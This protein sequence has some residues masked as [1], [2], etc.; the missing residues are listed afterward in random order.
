MICQPSW[1]DLIYY[2]G[3]SG[4][5]TAIIGIPLNKTPAVSMFYW[6]VFPS[7]KYN[8]LEKGLKEFILFEVCIFANGYLLS[9]VI[10]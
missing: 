2:A 10:S 6:G 7:A 8:F 1:E 5:K 4:K 9:M 3:S